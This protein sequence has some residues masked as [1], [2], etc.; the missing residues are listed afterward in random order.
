MI[1]PL[2]KPA[3]RS[4]SPPH[5]RGSLDQVLITAAMD[6]F[7]SY[8]YRGTSLA[9]IA[10]AAG[11]TK[12]ALYWHFTDK[13]D[14]FLAVVD[15]V[16]GDWSANVLK[17]PQAASRAGYRSEFLHIFAKNAEFNEKNPWVTRLLMIITLESHK[18]GPRVL[19]AMR[20]AN[21]G[22]FEQLRRLVERGKTLGAFD[23]S[24][25]VP[26]AASQMWTTT[27]G[28]AMLWYLHGPRFDLH[29][30]LRRQ[31][32]EFLKDWSKPSIIAPPVKN[33]RLD[34][35]KPDHAKSIQ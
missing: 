29:R 19:R 1:S 7:A 23:R 31:A 16:L 26:W 33:A 4:A 35:A 22:Q 28:L 10:R 13:E 3:T 21:L 32:N 14:F 9:R 15:K 2:R 8:G 34:H 5:R 30:A 11:V 18:I 24:L 27:I 12:G 6:L 25:D 20:R 17:M